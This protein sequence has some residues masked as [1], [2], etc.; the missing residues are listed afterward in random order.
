M[1]VVENAFVLSKSYAKKLEDAI[2]HGNQKKLERLLKRRSFNSKNINQRIGDDETP[3]S[4]A[5]LKGNSAAALLLLKHG[6]NID[7]AKTPPLVGACQ[8]DNLDLIQL[9]LTW[10]ADANV[11]DADGVTPLFCACM[12]GDFKVALLLSQY[13]ATIDWGSQSLLFVPQLASPNQDIADFVR[14]VH[15]YKGEKSLAFACLKGKARAARLLLR[16]GANPNEGKTHPIVGAYKAGNL[17]LARLLLRHGADVDHCTSDKQTLLSSACLN[18]NLELS[19]FLLENGATIG[20]GKTL[21]IIGACKSG[22]RDLI[23]LLLDRGANV[24]DI[25][26]NR[27]NHFIFSVK[28]VDILR[29]LLDHGANLNAVD[30]DGRNLLFYANSAESV[31]F[32]VARGLQVAST[33]SRQRHPLHQVTNAEAARALIDLGAKI[34]ARSELG[35]TALHEPVGVHF[36][37]RY[38]VLRELLNNGAD[39]NVRSSTLKRTP[40]HCAFRWHCRLTVRTLVLLLD[41]GA[42]INARDFQGDTPLHVACECEGDFDIIELLLDRGADIHAVSRS[43]ESPLH[44]ACKRFSVRSDLVRLLLDR[45]AVAAINCGDVLGNTPLHSLILAVIDRTQSGRHRREYFEEFERTIRLLVSRGANINAK[46]DSGQTPLSLTYCK[47]VTIGRWS[48]MHTTVEVPEL[49]IELIN[50][51]MSLGADVNVPND[52]G[53][54]MLQ[55]ICC[56]KRSTV[57]CSEKY[58]R[59]TID[60]CA[61]L[62]AQNAEGMTALHLAC[63]DDNKVNVARVLLEQGASS[64]IQ[65]MR[66]NTPLHLACFT[67]CWAAVRLLLEFNANPMTENIRG[68]GAVNTIFSDDDC[69]FD[70]L[71]LAVRESPDRLAFIKQEKY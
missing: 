7:D 19:H 43:L 5:C 15:L 32:L 28:D 61:D 66:L 71:Y 57:N 31:H 50:L 11:G 12:K 52:Q 48:L 4:L 59:L 9:L 45:D 64:S 63:M 54:T 38:E 70:L 60:Y 68:D 69:P 51:L 56:G 1:K 34:E 17:D 13:G 29:L 25:K 2:V 23:R 24:K 65:N 41:H 30:K 8:S 40:L 20:K 16:H 49:Q 46:N 21:P 22:N 26:D 6:A 36:G 47:V 27:G 55:A 18:G 58:A 10:G 3:L 44:Y 42:L 39:V 33:D 35:G 62:D 37:H 53:L 67:R 14:I